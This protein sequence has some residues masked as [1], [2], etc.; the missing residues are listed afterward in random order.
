MPININSIN[1]GRCFINSYQFQVCI[2]ATKLSR[3]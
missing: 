3:T 1:Y 2:T